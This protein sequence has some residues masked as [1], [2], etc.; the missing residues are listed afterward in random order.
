M[1]L[2]P[3]AISVAICTEKTGEG[4]RHAGLHLERGGEKWGYVTFGSQAVFTTFSLVT[5]GDLAFLFL[6]PGLDDNA[7]VINGFK[8]QMAIF[9]F[10]F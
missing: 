9:A 10:Q 1:F 4:R 2:T 5:S 8:S 6:A 7:K 3:V